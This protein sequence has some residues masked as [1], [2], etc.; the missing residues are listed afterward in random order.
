MH[1]II[2]KKYRVVLYAQGMLDLPTIIN[3]FTAFE[4]SAE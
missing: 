3:T 4:E 2:F 1:K